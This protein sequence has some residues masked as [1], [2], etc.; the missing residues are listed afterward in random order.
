MSFI[1]VLVRCQ[2]NWEKCEISSFSF[3]RRGLLS[4]RELPILS[5]SSPLSTVIFRC[6]P[7]STRFLSRYP[8]SFP[9][10][11]LSKHD[12]PDVS[13]RC[14]SISLISLWVD[15]TRLNNNRTDM[16]AFR[17]VRDFVMDTQPLARRFKHCLTISYLGNFCIVY[18]GS[19]SQKSLSVWGFATFLDT[20][21]FQKPETMTATWS[22]PS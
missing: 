22:F 19:S 2:E 10:Y 13:D 3:S 18:I 21:S 1:F 17:D 7:S 20:T 5:H 4:P 8:L 14:N 16:L 9:R 15:L 6:I 11:T 12:P